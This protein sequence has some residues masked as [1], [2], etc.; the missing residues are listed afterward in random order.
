MNF[1]IAVVIVSYNVKEDLLV[2]LSSLEELSSTGYQL[3]IFVVDNASTDGSVQAIKSR[4]I[5]LLKSKLNLGFAGGNN[6]GIKQALVWGADFILV[7]NPDTV[8]DKSLTKEFLQKIEADPEIGIVGPKIYFASGYEFHGDRYNQKEQGKVIWWAGGR[9]DWDNV[10]TEHTGVDKVDKGQYNS[11]GEMETIPGTA[12][13]IR[14][15]VFE[16]VG[17]FDEKYF[18][19]FEE[20]DFCRRVRKAG[21][22]L[23]YEPKAIV[24]HKNAQSSGVGSGL[25][26]Y[27]ITRNRLLFGFKYAPLRS[28]FNLLKEAV[29]L[30][31]TGRPWQKRGVLDFLFGRFGQGSFKK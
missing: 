30:V 23:W 19:Y 18:L 3:K 27:Y 25:Q 29:K 24:W 11:G 2:C 21:F 5:I 20:S 6:L 10:M 12:M 17:F 8:V 13:F 31:S 7:L 26:D 28:K 14:R 4:N 16:K 1:K 9:I 15:E 22:K